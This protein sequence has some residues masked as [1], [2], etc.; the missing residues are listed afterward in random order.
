MSMRHLTVPD[1]FPII[2]RFLAA[3]VPTLGV[4]LSASASVIARYDMNSPTQFLNNAGTTFYQPDLVN[5]GGSSSPT[6]LT[7]GGAKNSG[8][9]QFD[10]VDDYLGF[11]N[12]GYLYI[13][14][15]FSN[16]TVS[17]WIKTTDTGTNSSGY[18]GTPKVPVLGNNTD[19]VGFGIGID[20]GRAT[21]KRYN[22][23]WQTAQ[24]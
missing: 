1:S 10:G 6:Y 20:G 17:F 9:F 24:G 2:F 22:G 11:N 4:A 12:A 8:A 5:P 15:S 7:S 19:S 14:D 18:A 13:A 23:G 3:V 21:Y 16:W